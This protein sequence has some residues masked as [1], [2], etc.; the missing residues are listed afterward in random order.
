MRVTKGAQIVA[1]T[2]LLALAVAV[3]LLLTPNTPR[4]SA[5]RT[6]TLIAL[7]RNA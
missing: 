4:Y 1:G 5:E 7:A 3:L 6:P 2:A